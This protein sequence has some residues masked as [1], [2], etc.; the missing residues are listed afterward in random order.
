MTRPRESSQGGSA[1]NPQGGSFGERPI[2]AGEGSRGRGAA[3]F[4]GS[5]LSLP[6]LALL[7][8]LAAPALPALPQGDVELLVAG[9]IGLLLVAAATL[10]LLPAW[11]S[12]FA[13]VLLGLG[14]GLLAAALNSAGVGAGAN[15][16]EALLAAAVG[17]LFARALA[18]PALA[19]AVP[20]FVALIDAWSVASG[21]T[22]R[23]L[24]GGTQ[25]GDPLSFDVPAWGERGS[26]G[27]VGLVDALFLAMFAGWVSRHDLRRG[28]TICSMVAGLIA[29][30]VLGV[31]LDRAIP[32]LPLIAAGFLLPNA[33]RLWRRQ[34]HV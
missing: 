15:V 30:L 11:D 18:A 32:A 23:L 29:A 16:V 4:G 27:H 7:Y 10:S 1:A 20:P 25:A 28:L 33:D 14:A 8:F 21:P 24:E 26:A 17:L 19:L 13:L 5:G 22:Q 6:G 3:R 12:P 9:A 2:R 34:R 31:A